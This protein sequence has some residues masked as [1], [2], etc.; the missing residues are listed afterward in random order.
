M[1]GVALVHDYLTQFGGAERVAAELCR[2]FP[3]APLYTT[4][5]RPER[6]WADF[7]GVDI[8]CSYLQH[9]GPLA[10]RH[11]TLL[12]LYPRAIERLR[13]EPVGL[14]LSNSSA[15]AKGVHPPPGA[16]HVCYCHNPM[17]FAWRSSDYLE[18]EQLPGVVKRALRAYMA[19]LREWDLER[20]KD[21]DLFLANSANVQQRI[22]SWYKRDSLVLHPPTSMPLWPASPRPAA[23]HILVVSRLVGYKRI[24]LPIEAARILG[25]P[26]VV[27]GE[28]PDRQRLEGLAGGT[29]RFA[30]RVS[31]EELEGL[32]DSAVAL[33]FPGEE[34][35]GLVPVEAMA[36]GVPVVAFAAGGALETVV[37]GVTGVFFEQETADDL[38]KAL[39]RCLRMTWDPGA[40]RQQ[41]EEFSAEAFRRNLLGILSERN[42]LT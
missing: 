9:L 39:D 40:L 4:V 36:R 38:A 26:L 22:A 31:D 42:C 2:I 17:R 35:F 1:D 24:D 5:Y 30:G 19:R 34:D 7:E 14:V 23:G 11:R 20:N 29:V 6:T 21:V 32:Y 25:M 16:T 3:G 8:R 12:P 13:I 18:R 28:G 41:A 33:A 37:E 10:N 27:V 15:F